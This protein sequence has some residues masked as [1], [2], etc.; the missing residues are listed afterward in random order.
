ME[1]FNTKII[2]FIYNKKYINYIIFGAFRFLYTKLKK[3]MVITC[4]VFKCIS[5]ENKIVNQNDKR[6]LKK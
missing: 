4:N 1:Y 3:K 6:A 2:F 5:C